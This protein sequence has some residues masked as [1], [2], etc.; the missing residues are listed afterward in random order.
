VR[1]AVP[2]S[3]SLAQLPVYV[4]AGAIVPMQTLIQST[5]ETPTG[6]LILR[7]YAG[8]KCAGQLYLDDGKSFAYQEGAFLRERFMCEVRDDGIRMTI[9]KR[10]GSYPAW[11]KQIRVEIYGW[12]PS[13]NKVLVNG[14]AIAT[15]I[16]RGEHNVTFDIP[17]DGSASTVEVR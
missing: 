15:R 3:P 11:W 2:V 4:R 13:K 10:E 6:P 16:N 12:M 5:N 8:D 9:S 14:V 1:Y 17:V 7:V